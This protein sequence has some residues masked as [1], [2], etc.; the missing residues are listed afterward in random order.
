MQNKT[1]TGL[2][3]IVVILFIIALAFLFP[4]EK[5]EDGVNDGIQRNSNS[6]HD[7]IKQDNS[8][9]LQQD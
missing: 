1:K 2:I 5:P 8:E 9:S 3:W 4:Y 6:I 7:D